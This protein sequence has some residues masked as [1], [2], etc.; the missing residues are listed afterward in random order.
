MCSSGRF[1][2]QEKRLNRDVVITV[3]NNENLK[4]NRQ[5]VVQLQSMETNVILQLNKVLIVDNLGYNLLSVSQLMA[6]GIH[7]ECDSYSN[8]T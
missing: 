3:A 4:T 6:K 1:V 2:Q 5:G 8:E 7:L